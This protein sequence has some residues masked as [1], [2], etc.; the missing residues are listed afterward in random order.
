MSKNVLDVAVVGAGVSGVYCAWRLLSTGAASS[1]AVFESSDRVGGRLLSAMPPG[2]PNMRAELGGARFLKGVQTR[3]TNLVA[4]LG[5][6]T[7]ALP[8]SDPDELIFLRGVH[9]RE[10]DYTD[11]GWDVPYKLGLHEKGKS[12]I[13]LVIDAVEQIVPGITAMGAARRR[14][15]VKHASFAGR[16]LW[17][18]GLWSVLQRVMSSEACALGAAAAGH[19]SA[20]Q[21]WN[22]VDAIPWLLSD[23]ALDGQYHG[24]VRGFE[25]VPHRLAEEVTQADG[26]I[27]LGRRLVAVERPEDDG[28]VTLRFDDGDPVQAN[29]V[30][31]AMPRRS[32]ELLEPSGPVFG[33][34]S[35][36]TLLASVTPRP[37]MRMFAAYRHPWWR[38]TSVSGGRSICDLPIRQ[39]EYCANPD[40]T[41]RRN[42]NALLMASFDD[43]RGVW[44][45]MRPRR[46]GDAIDPE[47]AGLPPFENAR[48]PQAQSAE[49]W[50]AH[51][52][53]NVMVQA[54]QRQLHE[55]HGVP[56]I[57]DPYAAAFKD[58]GADP[59]GG[60]WN[61]WN[62]GVRSWEIEA[63]IQRPAKGVPVYVCGEAYSR[64]QGWVEGALD[65]ADQV[66]ARFFGVAGL[67]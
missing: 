44:E 30:I 60:G 37:L 17:Q 6:E 53:P 24:F 21:S 22:A 67:G 51:P 29:A 50:T 31:L 58:W 43:G 10:H 23:S 39:V 41:P 11:R 45:G 19:L 1:V 56:F 28:P 66:L 34:A 33:E 65:T 47:T 64:E 57:P 55:L 32:L 42:G 25:I 18:Q 36:R 61:T 52:A 46:T 20:L 49:V 35:V 3:I 12:A 5:V 9:L 14:E 54:L 38:S 63:A 59:F 7:F 13:E 48:M 2:M 27:E 40:G 26:R 15:V 62:V 8:A 4:V 16:P